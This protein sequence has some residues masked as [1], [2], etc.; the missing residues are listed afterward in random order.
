M[1]KVSCSC[2]RIRRSEPY[3]WTQAS[4]NSGTTETRVA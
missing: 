2:S 1:F 3:D 4:A